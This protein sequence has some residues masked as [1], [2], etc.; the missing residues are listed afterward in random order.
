MDSELIEKWLL[1]LKNEKQYSQHTIRAY[2]SD[3]QGLLNFLAESERTLI[4]T[5]K[6]DIR[7]FLAFSKKNAPSATTANRKISAIKQLFRWMQKKKQIS[8]NPVANISR[9]RIPDHLPKILEIDEVSHVVENPT[10]K[11]R[12]AIRNR[13]IL[14]LLYGAGI[15]VSE[16]ATLDIEHVDFE[17]TLVRVF[18]KGKKTRIV[19]FGPPAKEALQKWLSVRQQFTPKNTEQSLFLNKNG[20][21]LSVRT[22]WKICRDSGRKNNIS[23]LHPH[24]MRHSCATHLLSSGADLRSIQEQLGHSSLRTTQRYT[25]VDISQLMDVYRKTHPSEKKTNDD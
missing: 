20:S 1:F 19:P 14:E 13:A 2:R 3:I 10:Q 15:R 4:Q 7:S 23:Q 12:F 6:Y 11:G 8:R 18:G 25:Q 9:P 21:R 22:M 17:Q 16:A 24:A 5:D